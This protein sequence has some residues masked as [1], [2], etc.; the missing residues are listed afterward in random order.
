[1]IDLEIIKE[2]RNKLE[3]LRK[4]GIK[5]MHIH[6]ISKNNVLKVKEFINS[7]KSYLGFFEKEIYEKDN[8]II[9]ELI[10]K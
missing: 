4:Y 5:F 2:I 6:G 1:M 8:I 3:I 10:L 7:Q 9:V